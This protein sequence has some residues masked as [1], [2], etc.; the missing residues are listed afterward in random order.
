[1][2]EGYLKIP[3][4]VM[5]VW[6]DDGYGYI[7]DKGQVAAGQGTYYHVAMM[8]NR[9]NQL[10]EMVPIERITGEMGRFVQAR[11]TNY[12]LVNTS[13]I[14]PYTL[15]IRAV[16]DDAWLGHLP[17]AEEAP[18]GYYRRWAAEQFGDKAAPA[19]A[20][21][22]KDYFAAPAHLEPGHQGDPPR[23]YGDQI[24]HTESRQNDAD[25]DD[26][27]AAV[28]DSGAVAEVDDAAAGGSGVWAGTG[29]WRQGVAAH[30]GGAGDPAV[31]RR[32]AALGC[33]VEEGGRG[34][35]AGTRCPPALLS[36][37]CADHGYN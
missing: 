7:Q 30:H 14:R 6:A 8:N 21:M 19:I 29:V 32:A 26:R 13:D 28:C 31:R 3:P 35:D 2:Q 22:Y 33:C 18:A 37:I 34:G 9:T 16:M 11:A 20:G 24:Y 23:E 5:T 4:E 17:G 25:L 27:C 15:T 12:F 36:G 10:T 1:V